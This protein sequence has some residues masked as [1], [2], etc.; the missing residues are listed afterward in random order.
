MKRFREFKI[1]PITITADPVHGSHSVP[2]AKKGAK[3]VTIT[4]QPTHGSHSVSED[5]Q[6][7]SIYDVP[8]NK[9][10]PALNDHGN[11]HIGQT[12]HEVAKKLHNPELKKAK[13]FRSVEKYTGFSGDINQEL[14]H[15]AAGKPG[16]S[17]DTDAYRDLNDKERS[18]LKR[19]HARKVTALDSFI[20]NH[21]RTSH[22]MVVYHGTHRW[23]PGKESA[24]HPEGHIHLPAYTSTSIDKHKANAFA[25]GHTHFKTDAGHHILEIHLPKGHKGVYLGS[26]SIH[27]DEKEFLLP[28]GTNLKIHPNPTKMS[29]TVHGYDYKEKVW[30]PQQKEVHVWKATPV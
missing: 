29:H 6:E 23:N 7:S 16:S 5:L 8:V 22:D 11:K 10:D 26:H 28:R 13:G 9:M 19:G 20:D 18:T 24:K 14:I 4:A 2:K 1:E 30:K 27:D 3:P 15:K 17:F 12:V 21:P 25:A